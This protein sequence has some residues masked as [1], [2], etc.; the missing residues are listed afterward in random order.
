MILRRDLGSNTFETTTRV[1]RYYLDSGFSKQ[2]VRRMLDAFVIQCDP[3]ASLPLMSDL[4]DNAVKRASKRK[5]V[6]VDSIPITH[7]EM[8]TIKSLEQRQAKRLAF[9]LL[10][11]AKYLD[12]VNPNNDHW[13]NVKDSEIMKMANISTS[14]KRQ[15]SIYRYLNNLG[16]ISFSKMVDNTNVRVLF[17]KANSKVA[18]EVTDM[19]NLGYQYM[20]FCGEEG[21]YVCQNCGLTD[22]IKTVNK[23][24][25]RKYCPE[26]AM[27]I[28]L[29][30][31][32][33][34]VMTHYLA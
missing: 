10:V 16:L 1:A 20:K 34:A 13:V 21:Y 18:L 27:K 8:R 4:L 9:V 33:D 22:K 19:R 5:A 12:E 7:A 24:R 2:E 6:N 14:L 15:A 11:L 3:E 31:N 28:K 23:R 29:K 30:K 32:V 25:P 26:C 17:T